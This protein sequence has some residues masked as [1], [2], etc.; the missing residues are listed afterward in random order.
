MPPIVAKDLAREDGTGAPPAEA[1][2]RMVGALAYALLRVFQLSA[3]VTGTAPS[4]ALRE[5]Q[6][7]FAVE[8]FER[9][10]VLRKR[11][12]ALTDD[13]EAAMTPFR[14]PLDS[15]FEAAPLETW[16]DGQVFQY[17]GD[18]IAT[19]FADLI[20]PH[21]D[22]RT[23][24]AVREGIAGRGAHEAFALEQILVA[25][26]QDPVAEERVGAATAAIVGNALGRLREAILS[27]DAL[28]VILGGEGHVKELVLEL[29]GRH[30]ERLERLGL[31]RVD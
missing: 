8:E 23:A 2:A 7:A 13:P 22:E 20:G 19:D 18:A 11:L 28:A 4:L 29:L 6:A 17:I 31:D 16:L 21:L 5:R 14:G 15:F 24:A 3:A 30:R 12:T 26:A 27:S 1:A 25:L 9:Y 10:R